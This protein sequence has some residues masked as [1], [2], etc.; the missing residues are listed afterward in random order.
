MLTEGKSRSCVKEQTD[1]RKPMA[2]PPAPTCYYKEVKPWKNGNHWTC[3]KCGNE[4][5]TEF[6]RFELGKKHHSYVE[7]ICDGCGFEW[8][9]IMKSEGWLPADGD[10]SA[11]D[12]IS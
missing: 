4:D 10:I 9:I 11:D 7:M 5:T 8:N 6:G 12:L 2:P 3:P 1:I